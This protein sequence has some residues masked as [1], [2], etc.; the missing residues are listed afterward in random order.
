[1]SDLRSDQL[2]ELQTRFPVGAL[3]L[4]IP[5]II[6]DRLTHLESGSKMWL[7]FKCHDYIKDEDSTYSCG[8]YGEDH[9]FGGK[10]AAP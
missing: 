10:P 8:K 9:D 5:T 1:V 4:D 7:C 2:V 3:R 6:A